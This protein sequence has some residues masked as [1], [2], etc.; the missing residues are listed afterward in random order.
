[1]RAC[2]RLSGRINFV[3]RICWKTHTFFLVSLSALIPEHL[4]V[5]H[6]F[7][8]FASKSAKSLILDLPK[9]CYKDSLKNNL[10]IKDNS[11]SFMEFQHNP[12]E[13]QC[14][15]PMVLQVPNS[16]P[17]V[18]FLQ[19]PPQNSRLRSLNVNLQFIQFFAECLNMPM[20]RH[21]ETTFFSLF[22][23]LFRNVFPQSLPL[24]SSK[25]VRNIGQGKRLKSLIKTFEMLFRVMTDVKI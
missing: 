14:I 5:T 8:I 2:E 12:L 20:H 21:S 10:D 1:M 7:F 11:F 3:P 18:E 15:F 25:E 6:F 4:I 24:T 22:S 13:A 17:E 19:G 16:R 9:K 23:F